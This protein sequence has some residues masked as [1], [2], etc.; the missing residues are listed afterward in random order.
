MASA[1]HYPHDPRKQQKG[2]FSRR[3]EAPRLRFHQSRAG[4]EGAGGGVRQ[5][6]V[7]KMLLGIER[8]VVEDVRVE[9]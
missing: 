2:R 3:S 8:A 1:H 6:S 7:W 4:N 5:R 9:L